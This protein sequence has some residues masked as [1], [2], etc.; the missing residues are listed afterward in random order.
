[1]VSKIIGVILL[2]MCVFGAL[3][4]E[5]KDGP[6]AVPF[7][8]FGIIAL[9]LLFRKSKT[10]EQKAEMK[11]TREEQ[12]E[13]ESSH[14]TLKHM[15]G[16]PIAEGADCSC[17]LEKETF[18]CSGE[19]TTFNLNYNKITSISIKTDVEI[20][21]QYV[22][23]IGGAVGGAVLFGPLGA[24]VGGRAKK[25]K[26]VEKTYFLIL[27]Y[28]KEGDVDYISFEI[29]NELLNKANKIKSMFEKEYKQDITT[30]IEL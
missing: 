13:F 27:T 21:Q 18:I 26:N 9:I 22:S 30:T 1:M 19:G 23:S 12:K 5:V 2:L 28:L 25:K 29:P 14:I 11:Q 17:G 6:S 24:M 7:I 10:K 8:F 3:G 20:Q 4:G 15:T 16:L